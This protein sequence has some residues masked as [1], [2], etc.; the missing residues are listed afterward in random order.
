MKQ[1][2]PYQQPGKHYRPQQFIKTPPHKGKW[3]LMYG[4]VCLLYNSFYGS[5]VKARKECNRHKYYRNIEMF[6]IIPYV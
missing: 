5:C 2:N 3:S 6:S 1:M 4:G